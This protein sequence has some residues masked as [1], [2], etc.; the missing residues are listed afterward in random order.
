MMGGISFD[1]IPEGAM[2]RPA[3]MTVAI[4]ARQIGEE[5]ARL[6]LR[7]IKSPEGSLESIILRPKL[8]IRSSCR[9]G[10]AVQ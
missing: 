2:D 6:L 7:R 3:L 10:P 8:I 4:G 5:A 1:N 9:A